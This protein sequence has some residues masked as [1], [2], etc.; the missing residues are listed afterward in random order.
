MLARVAPRRGRAHPEE[1]GYA[2]SEG[3]TQDT[4]GQ[5]VSPVASTG[6]SGIRFQLLGAM[7]AFR[8]DHCVVFRTRKALALLAYLAVESGPQ[9]REQL[10][11]LLWPGADAEAGRASLR[12]ALFYVREALG[13]DAEAVLSVTRER[14][15]VREGAP[16]HLDLDD[17][18][19]AQALLRQADGVGRIRRQL[20]DAVDAYRGTFLVGVAFPD[21]PD[22]EAWVEAQRVRW[23]AVAVELL[24]GL[25]SV[26]R[27]GGD[28]ASAQAALERLTAIDP[29]DEAGWRELLE[30]HLLLDDPSAA[31][32]GW[33]AYES[34]T[35][36]LAAEPSAEML[37]LAERIC[38][39]GSIPP[40]A[41]SSAVAGESLERSPGPPFIGRT[42]ECCRLREAFDRARSGRTEVVCIVGTAG[43]GKTRLGVEF[44][45]AAGGA[46]ADVLVGRALEL[47]GELRYATV[48]GALRTRLERENAPEDLLADVWLR[49][50]SR[51][52]PELRERYPDLTEAGG[53]PALQ[54]ALLFE[55]V[56]RLGQAL[57]RRRPLVLWLDDVQWADAGTRD[58]VR[59]AVRRWSE[60]RT[61]VVLLLS[62]RSE[63]PDADVE[64]QRWLASMERDVR[65]C[66]LEIDA[67]RRDDLVRLAA[68][69]TGDGVPPEPGPSAVAFGEWL[70]AHTGGLPQ[71]VSAVL[72]RM[73]ADGHLRFRST[74][75][76][77]WALD[78]RP[79]L[80]ARRGRKTT[81]GTHSRAGAG[82]PPAGTRPS[83]PRRRRGPGA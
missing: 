83:R 29:A 25:A 12:T 31:Q 16:L 52:L 2:P 50:L 4:V 66:W 75:G 3:G 5:Q 18:A 70:E 61:S 59:Y 8:G 43:S 41:G 79:L 58:L 44:A 46:G 63:G 51:V 14:V 26:Y 67:L 28:W 30:L 45:A 64:L 24:H 39:M 6:M 21:A 82:S 11:D 78:V 7:Q 37:G 65:P 62:A 22:F 47:S 38:G 53:D 34:A 60:T 19:E 40:L 54:P 10:A 77:G 74:D 36:R 17:L 35:S 42:G 81:P 69:L 73:L 1:R 71:S 49:E 27:E 55:A 56:V 76:A 80:R 9:R 33:R 23:L 13:G 32:R 72:D 57:A 20:E 15:G 68:I 48:I